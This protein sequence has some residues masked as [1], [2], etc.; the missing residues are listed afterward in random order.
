M[1][2]SSEV[3]RFDP[4]YL[5]VCP[6]YSTQTNINKFFCVINAPKDD[7]WEGLEAT[8]RGVGRSIR[9]SYVS[10]TMRR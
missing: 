2:A 3:H 10:H 5:F 8:R 6:H 9:A 7:I 4:P 1:A